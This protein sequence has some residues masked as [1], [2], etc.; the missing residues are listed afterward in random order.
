MPSTGINNGTLVAVYY[1]GSKISNLTSNSIAISQALRA[2][3]TKDSAGWEEVLEG[4]RSAEITCDGYFA[5]DATIG[6]TQILADIITTR[7][8]VTVRWSSGVSGDKYLQGT[9][10]ISSSN[11]S[12]GLEESETFSVT[13]KVTGALTIGTV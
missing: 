8:T 12:A 3:T 5:E 11:F 13:F 10:Y 9:A 1:D 7:G 4:L 2:A 6:H